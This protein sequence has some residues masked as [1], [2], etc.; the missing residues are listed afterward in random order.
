MRGGRGARGDRSRG[1]GAAHVRDGRLRRS[2]PGGRSVFRA[3]GPDAACS[4]EALGAGC[5]TRP[6]GGRDAEGLEIHA[7]Q[8]TLRAERDARPRAMRERRDLPAVLLQLFNLSSAVGSGRASAPRERG[9]HAR[10]LLL[11]QAGRDGSA[12]AGGCSITRATASGRL[13][14]GPNRAIG[15]HLRDR[16]FSAGEQ[17]KQLRAV[18]TVATCSAASSTRTTVA[19]PE[20]RPEQWRPVRVRPR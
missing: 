6:A 4:R 14:T 16:T 10:A 8:D 13:L 18:V 9:G 2:R 11:V 5:R 7:W 17:R 12:R 3:W 19:S 1:A 20:Q 15:K